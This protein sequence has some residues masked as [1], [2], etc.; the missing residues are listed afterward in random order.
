MFCSMGT[1]MTLSHEKGRAGKGNPWARRAEIG[2][3]WSS[4]SVLV[5]SRL[6]ERLRYKK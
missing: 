4:L 1:G 2:E 5:S 3:P 6:N